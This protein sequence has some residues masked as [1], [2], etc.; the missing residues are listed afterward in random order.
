[1]QNRGPLV[2]TD[3]FA[4][5]FERLRWFIVL[6]TLFLSAGAIYGY[7]HVPT[8]DNEE[9]SADAAAPQF[10][11]ESDNQDVTG[12]DRDVS[13]TRAGTKP[14]KVRR[15]PP[16]DYQQATTECV[17]VVEVDDLFNPQTVNALRGV[18]RELEALPQ[19]SRVLWLDGVP[20]LNM[21]GLSSPLLPP[22]SASAERF[23]S[24]RRDAMQHPLAQGQLISEDGKTLLMLIWLEWVHITTDEGATQ[25]IIEVAR[26]EASRHDVDNLRLRLTGR[27][28]LY[29]GAQKALSRNH[30]KFQIIGYALVLVLAVVLFRG[31]P[32]VII[33]AGAP[34][35]GIFWSHGWLTLF[36]QLDNPLTGAV[37][38]VLVSMVGFTD[39]VHLIVHI[40]SAR[41][42]GATPMAAAKSAIREVGL[43]CLLTS[44]TTAIGF[45]SLM[46]GSNEYVQGFG[47]A[48]SI[49]VMLTF[50]A[51][52]SFIP[53]MSTTRLGR[54]IHRGHE[55]DFVRS[56]LQ[57]LTPL[58]DWVVKRRILLSAFSFLLTFALLAW[59][60]LA[61][62][63]D[64][65]L[66]DS[67]PSGSEAYQALA[68]CDRV[69]GGIEMVEVRVFW[70]KNVQPDEVLVAIQRARNVLDSEP[71]VNNQLAIQDFIN[72][73]PG[74]QNKLAQ[75]AYLALLPEAIQK[76]YFNTKTRKAR[77]TGR[78][79]DLGIA[80]YEPAFSRIEKQLA[81]LK[82]EMPGFH[83]DLH[84]SPVHRGRQL[85]QIVVD[86]ATSLGTAS[87]IILVVMAI[88]YRS[89][90]IGLV[91]I[92][93]NLFP[94]VV[95]A[96]YLLVVGQPLEIAS[97]CSF[98]VCLGIAVDDSIH[99]LSRYQS[100]RRSGKRPVLAVRSTFVGVG[101]ALITTT[102]VL[103]AGFGTVLTSDLPG[104]RTF[105]SMACWTIGAALV[106]DLIF[107]PAL[108][109]CFD[110]DTKSA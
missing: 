64:D 68:H 96:A 19:V 108:L 28:P 7:L 17:L 10:R 26:A 42:N 31:I 29:M 58:I 43:A 63:P 15:L 27:V 103:I 79:Q 48:C 104:H 11:R 71:L 67:Q 50:F 49:G 14:T 92:V 107:L 78:I 22:S 87:V 98:T 91:T 37:L 66:S 86:L 13:E 21:F 74:S 51:V 35:L 3:F 53:L 55:R 94:L 72:Q 41:A 36:D 69:M 110:R 106:G 105:A 12:H 84:G 56:N 33:V 40:R 102:L 18:A 16:R 52:I 24:A 45:G 25:E 38:P 47:R 81:T 4:D 109:L 77:V 8:A 44:L 57:R 60:L 101:T 80:T 100:E 90:I 61:L 6:F 97:V 62:R 93:P 9:A 83:F 34:A 23:A 85:F 75:A 95:T 76:D 2:S 30:L 59:A 46:L 70:S 5:T 39:G 88:V 20:N 73:L 54:N 32:A 82:K 99:F 1:M 89:L 65:R